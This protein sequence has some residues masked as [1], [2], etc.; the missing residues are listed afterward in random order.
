MYVVL[1]ASRSLQARAA[2]SH[3]HSGLLRHYG[4]RLMSTT[5]ESTDPLEV[6]Y[7]RDNN[8]DQIFSAIS[9]DG[10]IKVTVATIRNII[11]D[12]SMQLTTTAVPTDALGRTMTCG[13]LMAN[14]MQA[15]QTVQITMKGTFSNLY[16][17]QYNVSVLVSMSL[18]RF[19]YLSIY[20]GMVL[21]EVL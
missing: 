3:R 18:I 21:C 17:S 14:G 1:I 13:L 2:F 11:N 7:N 20:K 9:G 4:T 6:Y 16:F 15:E 8:H 5:S 10:G 19:L 12:A